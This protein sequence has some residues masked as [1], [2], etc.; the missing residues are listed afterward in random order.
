MVN[1]LKKDK[2]NSDLQTQ[3]F[4]IYQINAASA[5]RQKAKQGDQNKLTM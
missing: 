3:S 4:R 5:M 2:P 1:F